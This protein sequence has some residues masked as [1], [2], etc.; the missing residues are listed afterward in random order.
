MTHPHLTTTTTPQQQQRRTTTDNAPQ[1]FKTPEVCRVYIGSFNA[2]A[3]IDARKNPECAGLFARERDA[4]LDDLRDIPARSCDRKGASSRVRGGEGG[5]LLRPTLGAAV[6]DPGPRP[7]NNQ[8][9][10]NQT[11]PNHNRTQ[12]NTTKPNPTKVNEFVKRVRALKIHMLLVGHIR[13]AMPAVFGKDKAQRRV[14]EELPDVFYAV[15]LTSV[16]CR[17][18][19]VVLC[20]R[21]CA[22]QRRRCAAQKTTA[23]LSLRGPPPSANAILSLTPTHTHTP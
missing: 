23:P 12:H 7:P 11:R 15:R 19:F 14:L 16:L 4:L 3:P 5:V 17:V 9:N 21:V 2:D 22:A 10:P 20:L 13:R 1:V 18:V 8:T 6:R